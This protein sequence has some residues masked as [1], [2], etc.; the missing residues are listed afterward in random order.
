MHKDFLNWELTN[1]LHSIGYDGDTFMWIDD[2]E[3]IINDSSV[4][5]IGGVR[6]ILYSQAFRWFRNVHEEYM[7]LVPTSFG[8]WWIKKSSKQTYGD[9]YDT[10]EEAQDA[11]LRKLIEIVKE[12]RDENNR[13]KGT[14]VACIRKCYNK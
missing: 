12:N 14:Y 11:C 4:E 5:F 8:Q 6:A 10:Y 1:I 7:V 13:S 2:E 9:K 3:D